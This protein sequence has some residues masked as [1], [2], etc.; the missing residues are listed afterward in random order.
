MKTIQLNS[1]LNIKSKYTIH[2]NYWIIF[3][4]LYRKANSILRCLFANQ[5]LKVCWF[6]FQ[7][8]N[9]WNIDFITRTILEIISFFYTNHSTIVMFFRVFSIVTMI[10]SSSF[11]FDIFFWTYV[12]CNHTKDSNNFYSKIFQILYKIHQ[13]NAK[14]QNAS[15]LYKQRKN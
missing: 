12:F 9:F 7:Y 3:Y 2:F 10:I 15:D 6:N 5:L 14:K 4:C 1:T 8:I 13:L 11:I